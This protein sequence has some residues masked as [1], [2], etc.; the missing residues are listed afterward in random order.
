MDRFYLTFPD[1][2]GSLHARSIYIA[3]ES[4]TPSVSHVRFALVGSSY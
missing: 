2:L 4:D 3:P 1:I